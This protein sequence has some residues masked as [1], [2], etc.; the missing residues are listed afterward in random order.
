MRVLQGV[1]LG[2]VWWRWSGNIEH[3]LD[4][5][6]HKMTLFVSPS[7][8]GCTKCH[9][10]LSRSPWLCPQIWGWVGGPASA[11][12]GGEGDAECGFGTTFLLLQLFYIPSLIKSKISEHL[13]GLSLTLGESVKEP[14]GMIL[15]DWMQKIQPRFLSAV[16]GVLCLE[17]WN[18]YYWTWHL[19]GTEIFVIYVSA[20]FTPY[21][22]G[23]KHLGGFNA[24]CS[25]WL[26]YHWVIVDQLMHKLK[27][28]CWISL[29]MF[30]KSSGIL[31]FLSTFD[32]GEQH[33]KTCT[34]RRWR[35]P[36]PAI[37]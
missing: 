13:S 18:R 35:N 15:K 25:P 14:A 21:L 7:A 32:E 3:L 8:V 11:T 12:F 16:L 9:K 22:S 1:W 36:R 2:C 23:Y 31:E 30:R 29:E 4:N 26:C 37:K 27:C 19:D 5:C 34:V 10:S 33:W 20:L 24:L 17:R 28:H 6:K